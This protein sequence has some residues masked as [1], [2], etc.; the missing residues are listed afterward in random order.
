MPRRT[1]QAAQQTRNHILDAAEQVFQKKGVG[2]TSLSDIADAAGVTRGAIYWHFKNKV[3]V[4]NQMHERVH[5]PIDAL[6]QASADSA[7]PDPLGRLRELM[8][9]V[10]QDTV[11]N[12]RQRRVLEILF[13]KCEL[14]GEMGELVARQEAIYREAYDRTER[15]LRNAILRGQLPADLNARKA[16]L[17]LHAY[18]RGII[19]NWLF[20]PESFDLAG[21]AESLI[22]GYLS[23]LREAPA[24]RR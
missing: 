20:L 13:H 6:A 22:D 4:F 14:I 12:P 24:M 10:L 19:T 11:N 9:L 2:H 1:K 16:S 3:D 5:L 18:I 17:G 21:D 8:V 23:M 7:E 15:V